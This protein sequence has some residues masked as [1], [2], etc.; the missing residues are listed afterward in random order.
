[1]PARSCLHQ[2]TSAM[3]G[4]RRPD[5]LRAVLLFCLL[6]A[7]AAG[8]GQAQNLLP[9]GT[10]DSDLSGWTRSGFVGVWSP[11]DADGRAD[12]GSASYF[13]DQNS[14][15]AFLQ[16][17]VN[18]ASGQTYTARG[19]VRLTPVADQGSQ[20]RFS[21]RAWDAPDCRGAS[22][23]LT[24]VFNLRADASTGLWTPLEGEHIPGPGVASL[25]IE[26]AINSGAPQPVEVN[27]DNLEF[28]LGTTCDE[29]SPPP[30]QCTPGPTTAC[31]LDGR[32]EVTVEWT[33][34][35]G[36]TGSGQIMEFQ[37]ARAASDES[38]FFWFFK[39]T[40]FEIGVK[41]VDACDP[42][43]ERYWVFV[44]GLTNVAFVVRVRDTLEGTERAYT[45]PLGMLP[46]TQGD[47]D[48][49]A[50]SP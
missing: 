31:L 43:F 1:M 6:S 36:G 41:M 32:F 21:V 12:S 46:Q 24:T 44:S 14:G 27:M 20:T 48:A 40:N 29:T 39:P 8:S 19:D 18:V 11:D 33:E 7:L 30:G 34:F 42:P 16:T 22:G 4:A 25:T 13:H 47:T 2:S 50:C 49:F 15:A 3:R 38:A 5:S 23:L 28:C 17:C 37:G 45:N 26:L 35:A 9:N 10:F